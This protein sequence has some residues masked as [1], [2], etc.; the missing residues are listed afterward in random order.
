MAED[1]EGRG[2]GAKDIRFDYVQDRV[3][4]ALKVRDDQFQRLLLGE[5]RCVHGDACMEHTATGRASLRMHLLS[6]ASALPRCAG[7][8]SCSSLSRRKRACCW[9]T[10]TARTCR[11]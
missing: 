3:C 11:W 8:R 5:T 6:L 10:W 2:T 7:R 9:S 1:G 4:S